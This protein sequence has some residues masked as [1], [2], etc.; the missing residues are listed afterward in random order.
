MKHTLNS[1]LAAAACLSF[2]LFP[3]DGA[4]AGERAWSEEP[5]PYTV[6]NQDVRGVL[7]ELGR[8]MNMSVTISDAVEGRVQGPWTSATVG[9]FLQRVGD[10]LD[11]EWFFDGRRLHVSAAGESVTRMLPLKGVEAEGWQASLDK[12]GLAN[13]RFP[14]T[15]DADQDI[16]L[17]SGPPSYVGLI[18]QSLPKPASTAVGRVNIIY[19]RNSRGDAS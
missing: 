18:V 5:Y 19:G 3:V 2:L 17:V 16:A 8:N 14:I 7:A 4:A 11:V 6:V 10:D 9:D 12:L 13:D 15:I 1:R